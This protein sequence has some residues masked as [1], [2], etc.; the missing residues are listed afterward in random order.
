MKIEVDYRELSF[1]NKYIEKMERRH[2]EY[3]FRKFYDPIINYD[4][5]KKDIDEIDCIIVLKS[6]E[7]NEIERKIFLEMW[8]K[9]KKRNEEL[10]EWKMKLI[11]K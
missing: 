7:L 3:I 6:I 11:K 2:Y 10:I 8:E 1:L 4:I 5:Y 9:I